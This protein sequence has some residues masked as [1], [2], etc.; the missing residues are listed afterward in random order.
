MTVLGPTASGKTHFACQLALE[1]EGEI[2]SADSRQVYRRM[3]IGTGKDLEEYQVNGQAI[4]YHLIDIKEPGYRYNIAEFETD[5]L[6]AYHQIRQ[7]NKFPIL[8]GGSGLYI[9]AALR[10]NDYHGIPSSHVF[11]DE[12]E[13]LTEDELDKMF[14]EVRQEL[15]ENLSAHTRRRKIRAIEMDIYLKEYPDFEVSKREEL[16]ALIIGVDVNRNV[17]RSRITRRLQER[18]EHGLVEE[19][20]SLLK[21]GLS[22]DDL[23][24]YGLEYKFVSS[25]LKGDLNRQELFDQLNVAIHQ[26]AKRQMT[27]FRRM[28]KNGYQIQWIPEEWTIEQKVAK[29]LELLKESEN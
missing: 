4:P 17:R 26:F 2:I 9:E 12:L 13:L 24:W 1:L 16:N 3:D 18:L 20:Q 29:T 10:G 23:E 25:Y 15:K 11:H 7:R 27:W 5:F 19:V 14:A 21:E 6:N 28:E 8:C 22:Y